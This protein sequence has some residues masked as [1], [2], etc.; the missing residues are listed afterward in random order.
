MR[1]ATGRWV[2][3]AVCLAVLC[4]GGCP[5]APVQPSTGPDVAAVVTVVKALY[6]DPGRIIFLGS[7]DGSVAGELLAQ[8]GAVVQE[9]LGV[10][11]LPE[12]A[13][14]RSDLSLPVL[15]P[16]DPETGELGVSI[17]LL[18]FQAARP[19]R[20]TVSAWY[21]RSGLGG[22]GYEITLE[23]TLAGWV[24]VQMEEGGVA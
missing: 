12:S 16:K 5:L 18:R 19:D 15:T 1:M 3:S 7:T 10:R 22:Q 14:D 20:L 6:A 17:D 4:L 9:E 13:A 24:I 8:A 2:S 11:V 21:A 23:R